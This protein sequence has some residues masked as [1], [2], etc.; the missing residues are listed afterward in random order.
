ML[1]DLPIHDLDS[2]IFQVLKVKFQPIAINISLMF[3]VTFLL[4]QRKTP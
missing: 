4:A 3:H 1:P 2:K